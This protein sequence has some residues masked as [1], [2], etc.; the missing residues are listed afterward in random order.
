MCSIAS[1][2]AADVYSPMKKSPN[3]LVMPHDVMVDIIQRLPT[4]EIFNSARKVCRTWQRI[5]KDPAMWKV[6]H[7]NTRYD[8]YDLEILTKHAVNLSC[9]ELIDISI[10]Y[11]GS[12]DLL[13]Y[14]ALRSSNLKCLSLTNCFH[15][16][17]SGLSQAVRKL[18]RLEKLHICLIDINEGDIEVIGKNCP[19]LKSFKMCKPFRGRFKCDYHAFAIAYYMPQLSHLE[20]FDIEMTNDGLEAILYGCPHLPSLDVRMCDNLDLGGNL[21]KL[22]MERIKDF[23]HNSTQ[24]SWF[25]V[26]IY[27]YAD[28]DAFY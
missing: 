25:D 22:C 18:A 9:G 2:S 24:N 19:Q 12:N 3:W 20:L 23:K 17:G 28:V 6:I 15:M 4:L 7:M 8:G 11:F 21:G 1:T 10:E 27:D 5:C 16:T 26:Q 13:N 14:I